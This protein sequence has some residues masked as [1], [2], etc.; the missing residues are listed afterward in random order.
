MPDPH[1]GVSVSEVE[2]HATAAQVK[3][4]VWRALA[5]LAAAEWGARCH[6]YAYLHVRLVLTLPGKAVQLPW[7]RT[8]EQPE[9][10]PFLLPPAGW[11]WLLDRRSAPALE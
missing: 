5:P 8:I 2:G 6:A 9:N 1:D 3:Q 7:Q 11:G 4:V 10:H